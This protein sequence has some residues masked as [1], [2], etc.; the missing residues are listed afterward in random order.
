MAFRTRASLNHYRRLKRTYWEHDIPLSPNQKQTL[1]N[2]IQT[3][4]TP[5]NDVYLYD[6]FYDN[7]STRIRDLLDLVVDGAL[8][9]VA[10]KDVL[11]KSFRDTVRQHQ[12]TTWMTGLGLSVWANHTMDKMLTGWEVMYLPGEV[13]V[14]AEKTMNNNA[15]LLTNKKEFGQGDIPRG[16]PWWDELGLVFLFLLPFLFFLIK[17][18]RSQILTS[19]WVQRVLSLIH[20]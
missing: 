1:Y 3:Q 18:L 17:T 15:P 20:I 7:C 19:S 2:A 6:F 12:S 9:T 5:P 4:L 13:M 10:T 14:Y 16:W 11:N 8:K